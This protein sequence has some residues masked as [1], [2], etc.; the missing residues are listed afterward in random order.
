MQALVL[1]LDQL[2]LTLC[3]LNMVA[4]TAQCFRNMLSGLSPEKKVTTTLTLYKDRVLRTMAQKMLQGR[5]EALDR[6]LATT[7]KGKPDEQ[8][9]PCL[10]SQQWG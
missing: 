9:G 8:G 2:S 10:L 3:D 6:F 4:F 1:P 7:P 5:H